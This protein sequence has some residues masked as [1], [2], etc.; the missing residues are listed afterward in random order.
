MKKSS[1]PPRPSRRQP[2]ARAPG[3]SPQRSSDSGAR[4]SEPWLDAAIAA[5]LVALVAVLYGQTAGHGFINL[6]D[7]VYIFSN[8]DVSRG[9]SWHGVLLAFTSFRASNWHPLTWLSHML[10]CQWFGATPRSAGAHHLVSAGFHAANAVLLFLAL[11]RMTR[12]RWRSAMV[13][14]LFAVHPLRVESVAWACER[15]DV[16]SG[17]FFMLTLL[18]YAR[19]AERPRPG[20]YLLALGMSVLGLLSKPM[21]VTLPVVLLLLDFWPLERVSSRWP[22]RRLLL[23]KTPFFLAA[24]GVSLLTVIAQKFAGAISTIGNLSIGWRVVTA[25]LASVT[26][27]WKAVW[28]SGLAVHYIHPGMLGADLKAFLLPAAAAALGI[29]AITALAVRERARRPYLLTGWLW[30]LVMLAPVS[31]LVQVGAQFWADRYAYLPLIGVSIAVVWGVAAWARRP[32][33]ARLAAGVAAAV[34]LAYTTAAFAQVRL[35]RDSRTLFEHALRVTRDNWVIENNL[36]VLLSDDDPASMEARRHLERAVQIRPAYAGAH[37]NLATVLLEQGHFAEAEAEWDQALRLQPDYPEASI[38]V[39][40]LRIKQGRLDEARARFEDALRR[41]PSSASA[42]A[43][44]GLALAS[45]GHLEEARREFETAL[46]LDPQSVLA[47]HGLARWLATAP[48]SAERDPRRALELARHAAATTNYRRPDI[49]ATLAAAYAAS[50]D[51]PQAIAWQQRALTL[52]PEA[53]RPIY[54]QRLELYQQGRTLISG[55]R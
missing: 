1:Q 32:A 44:L 21:L 55:P 25:A 26:Y 18:T 6:D 9:L 13:A 14:G 33:H 28:P 19:Y 3:D 53:Q 52:V 29:A 37:H 46:R 24:I 31:G 15:K 34:L 5:S 40:M 38:G 7:D 49:L 11:G 48:D 20:A 22:W 51:F 54:H 4:P 12:G 36:G 8:P 30:Y 45:S 42:H 23:E 27:L 17:F 16:L 2:A 43:H 39:G 47:E 10:D 41:D 35:W 50:G